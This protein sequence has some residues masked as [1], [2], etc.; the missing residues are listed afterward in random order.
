MFGPIEKPCSIV[1]SYYRPNPINI[2]SAM[3]CCTLGYSTNARLRIVFYVD[4]LWLDN[5]CPR[6]WSCLTL[7]YA[8]GIC[9]QLLLL[10]SKLSVARQRVAHTHTVIA[11]NAMRIAHAGNKSKPSISVQQCQ[12]RTTKTYTHD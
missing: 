8:Y 7:A 2:S 11:P 5:L 3:H 9:N 4:I 10:A 6:V 1:T 12:H